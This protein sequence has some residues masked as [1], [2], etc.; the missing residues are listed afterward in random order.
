MARFELRF[1]A[2]GTP[3]II[4]KDVTDA[5]RQASLVMTNADRGRDALNVGIQEKRTFLQMMDTLLYLLKRL[6]IDLA[7]C[8]PCERYGEARTDGSVQ[9]KMISNE[10]IEQLTCSDL[11]YYLAEVLRRIP[12]DMTTEIKIKE[13]LLQLVNQLA[14]I[15]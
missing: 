4:D 11:Q 15:Q 12:R 14:V 6:G 8:K 1:A 2:D 3:M 13:I 7:D 5:V 9:K 10:R